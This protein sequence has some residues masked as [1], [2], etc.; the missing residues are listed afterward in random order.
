M[1]EMT[2][3]RAQHTSVGLE[4]C[5]MFAE[6]AR[7]EISGDLPTV[8]FLKDVAPELVLHKEGDGRLGDVEESAAFRRR[9]VRQVADDVGTLVVLAHLVARRTEEGLQDAIL[10]VLLAQSLDE[11][12]TLLELAERSGMEPDVGSAWNQM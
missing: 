4:E 11:G 8:Q 2:E 3:H 10:R 1:T 12:T 6:N 9:V 5:L 7:N